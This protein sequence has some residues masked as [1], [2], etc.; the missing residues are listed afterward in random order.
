MPE[1]KEQQKKTNGFLAK[2][3]STFKKLGGGISAAWSWL[4]GKKTGIG[5]A[6]LLTSKVF[7]AHT[8]THQ[9]LSI[10]GELFGGI[11]LL[12]KGKKSLPEGLRK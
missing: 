12:H 4:D 2:V 6:A 7:P 11:G 5:T 1:Q 3:G 10:I 9:V 8:V